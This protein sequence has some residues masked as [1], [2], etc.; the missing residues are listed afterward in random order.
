MIINVKYIPTKQPVEVLD[1]SSFDLTEA[2]R[3]IAEQDHEDFINSHE[4][5]GEF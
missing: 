2:F 4:L 5:D 1:L 3:D